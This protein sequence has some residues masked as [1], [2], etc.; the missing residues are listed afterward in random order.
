L[1]NEEDRKEFLDFCKFYGNIGSIN[2]TDRR[3][4]TPVEKFCEILKRIFYFAAFVLLPL[5][6]EKFGPYAGYMTCVFAIFFSALSR[7]RT[8]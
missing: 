3:N 1:E 5:R 8:Y 2:N 6:S 7:L 4:M